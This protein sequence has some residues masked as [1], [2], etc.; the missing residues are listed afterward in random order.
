VNKDVTLE[1]SPVNSLRWWATTLRQSTG[2]F[3]HNSI[4]LQ[5]CKHAATKNISKFQLGQLMA[6]ALVHGG[7]AVHILLPSVFNYLSGM[8][9]CEI[10]VGLGGGSRY[11]C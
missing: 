5:V 7:A 1:G 2:C 4:V 9:P 10:I 6:M 11:W 3:K 8:K